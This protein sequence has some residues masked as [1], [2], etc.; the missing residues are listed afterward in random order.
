M[1]AHLFLSEA[2]I[3][4]ARAIHDDFKDRIVEPTEHVR[5]NVTV[6]DAPFSD[7]AV[8]GHV[9][10]T[11]GSV[12]PGEGHIDDPDLSVRLPYSIAR[13]LLVDQ[14]YEMIMITFMSGEIEVEGDITRLLS[15]QDFEATAEQQK[16]ADEIVGRLRSIT[17]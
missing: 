7:G 3:V 4:A 9:D 6:F 14:Q 11:T 8:I 16:L 10:T 5:M 17:A 2:W 12:V 15:L 13:Q 1:G